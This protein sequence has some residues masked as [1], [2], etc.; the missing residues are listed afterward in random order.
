MVTNKLKSPPR[1]NLGG[2][3]D[4]EHKN[5]TFFVKIMGHSDISRVIMFAQSQK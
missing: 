1:L 5:L 4:V 2:L 3:F